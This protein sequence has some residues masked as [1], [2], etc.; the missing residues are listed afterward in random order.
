MGRHTDSGRNHPRGKATVCR[1]CNE[2]KGASAA[3]RPITAPTPNPETSPCLTP[4]PSM[5]PPHGGLVLFS[6]SLDLVVDDLSRVFIDDRDAFSNR[7][8]IAR[9]DYRSLLIGRSN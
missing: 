8:I 9:R 1:P 3:G 5:R 6:R 4:R 2:N 7:N